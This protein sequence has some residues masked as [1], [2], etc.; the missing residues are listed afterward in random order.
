MVR[1][2]KEIVSFKERYGA[3]LGGVNA[4]SPQKSHEPSDRRYSAPDCAI[5]FSGLSFPTAF[6]PCNHRFC[7]PCVIKWS[8]R[9]NT[10]PLCKRVFDCFCDENGDVIEVKRKPPEELVMNDLELV[11]A[12]EYIEGLVCREC[13]QGDREDRL[14]L[15]DRCDACYHTFCLRPRLLRVPIGLWYCRACRLNN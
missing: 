15:C 6:L 4:T 10:C 13:G 8:E 9:S 14:L 2:S 1:R 7:S 5:C 12:R 11:A 3:L